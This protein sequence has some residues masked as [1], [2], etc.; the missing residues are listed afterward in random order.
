MAKRKKTELQVSLMA[1]R[2]TF[3]PVR[4]YRVSGYEGSRVI[5][6]H[7]RRPLA[8]PRTAGLSHVPCP[9][10]PRLG[11]G[12]RRA[13]F[14]DVFWEAVIASDRLYIVSHRT[15]HSPIGLFRTLQWAARALSRARE[16]MRV[17]VG[18]LGQGH[19]PQSGSALACWNVFPMGCAP[20]AGQARDGPL[21][22]GGLRRPA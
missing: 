12:S 10:T 5:A 4:P 16:F 21:P 3:P 8:V 18:I 14:R 7:A 11:G 17:G 1:S 15:K 13:S 2:R 19:T 22:Q 6:R 9:S 20:H